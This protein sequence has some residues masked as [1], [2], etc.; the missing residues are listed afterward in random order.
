MSPTILEANRSINK[1]HLSGGCTSH[2][3]VLLSDISG[4]TL[5]MFMLKADPVYIL[6]TC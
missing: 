1:T 3:V 4:Q 5:F 6:L 2:P